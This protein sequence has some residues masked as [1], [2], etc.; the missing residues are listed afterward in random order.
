[1]AVPALVGSTVSLL[2]SPEGG[3][4]SAGS[5]GSA[6]ETRVRIRA[7]DHDVPGVF[8]VPRAGV[9]EGPSPAVLMLH[10]FASDKD[11]VGGIYRRLAEALAQRGRASLR[12][13]F[14]GS[15][16]SEQSH[17]ELTYPGMV[18]D[19]RAALDWLVARP[20]TVG[21]RVGVQ[22]FSLGSM[23]G[24]TVAGT[25]PRVMGFA[26]MS[27]VIA[28]GGIH[29]PETLEACRANGGHLQLDLRY[30]TIDVSSAFFETMAAEHSLRD[31][32]RFAGPILLVIGAEDGTVDP[33]V[34]RRVLD[35]VRSLDAT[36]RILPG[37]DHIYQV[38]TPDQRLADECIAITA[39]WWASRL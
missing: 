13:D 23:V 21:A 22:G 33:Q 34:S 11:E 20:E 30:A 19:A 5:A 29:A 12:I 8:A 6:R 27:G 16:D 10:G 7:G 15:G 26:S 39:D 3:S 28:D 25:D 18:A 1:M 9:A 24:A 36:L 35:V 17:L 32:A 37:A 31:I 4:S 14:A 2:A 38:L